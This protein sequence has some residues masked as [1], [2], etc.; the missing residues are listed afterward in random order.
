[1]DIKFDIGGVTVNGVSNPDAT[2]KA[3]TRHISQDIGVYAANLV[4]NHG[5]VSF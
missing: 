4:G 2:G 3:V 5:L 1:M